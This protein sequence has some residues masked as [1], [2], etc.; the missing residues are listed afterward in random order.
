V[1]KVLFLVLAV[2]SADSTV[3]GRA[4]FMKAKG[5]FL[6]TVELDLSV[7]CYS[8]VGVKEWCCAGIYIF[9]VSRSEISETL[10]VKDCLSGAQTLHLNF[11]TTA[12]RSSRAREVFEIM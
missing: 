8:R 10:K 1:K 5:I 6:D 9:M 12:K 2:D 4:L 3:D 11:L 7:V